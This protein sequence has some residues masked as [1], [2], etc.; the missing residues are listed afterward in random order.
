MRALLFITINNWPALS[1]LSGQSNKGYNACT[2][3]FDDIKGI[4]LK[5]FRKIMYLGHRRFIPMNHALRKRDKHF[6]GKA[7]HRTKP[8]NHSG[9]DIFNMVKDVQVVFGKGPSSQ[10]VL[11]DANGHVD[12]HPSG[13]R[14]PY[15]GS[16]PTGKS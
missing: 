15:F 2:H 4:F 8:N 14:S 10:H 11:N 16:Y 12:T 6:K 3:C 7:E 5:K 13:R 9:E 1:N